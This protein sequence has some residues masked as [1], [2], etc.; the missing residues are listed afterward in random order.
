[1]SPYNAYDPFADVY[2]RHWGYF[3]DRAYPTL[4]HLVFRHLPEGSAVLDLCCGTGQL[5]ALLVEKDWRVTGL[6]G[7]SRMIDIAR[8]N[9]PKAD[10]VVQDARDIAL[11]G[12]FAAVVSTFDSLNH[13]LS[14]EELDNVFAGVHAILEDGGIFEFDLNLEEAY[15]TR[16]KGSFAFVEDDHVCAIRLKHD[17]SDRTGTTEITIFQP[18]GDAWQR[19]DVELLQRWYDPADIAESLIHA[20]FTSLSTY[21][22]SEPVAESAPK[23]PGRMYF[24][25]RKS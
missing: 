22:G 9:A 24:V 6:D 3:A 23:Q 25:A 21:D 13:V 8:R 19:S 20:G 17:E 2:T 14:L 7:S 18:D 16:W 10:F 5:A 4:E 12:P 11:D 15:L 1:M